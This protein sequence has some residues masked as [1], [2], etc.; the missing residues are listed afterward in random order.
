VTAAFAALLTFVLSALCD[1]NDAKS[2]NR[3]EQSCLHTTDCWSSAYCV[4]DSYN[5][6]KGHCQRIKVLW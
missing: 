4:A 2:E 5:S 3:I 6:E 1:P